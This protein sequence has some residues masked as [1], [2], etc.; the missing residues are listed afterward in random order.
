MISLHASRCP[1]S[2]RV[3]F[4]SKFVPNSSIASCKTVLIVMGGKDL[5]CRGA[6]TC[7]CHVFIAPDMDS[8]L[9]FESILHLFSFDTS[10]IRRYCWYE[11]CFGCTSHQLFL[12]SRYWC[13][14]WRIRHS[15]GKKPPYQ[16]SN[17]PRPSGVKIPPQLVFYFRSQVRISNTCL[18]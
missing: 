1:S 4:W 14:A 16:T 2:L 18:C 9:F 6:L 3:T 11:I 17:S 8:C 12:G 7:E 15:S 10:K 5:T 13:F